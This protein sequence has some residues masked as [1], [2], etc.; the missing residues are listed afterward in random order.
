MSRVELDPERGRAVAAELK[1]L[2]VKGILIT[3]AEQ[4]YITQLACKMPEC[5]CPEELGGACYFEPVTGRIKRLD[6]NPRALPALQESGGHRLVDNAILAHRLCNRIDYSPE[7]SRVPSGTARSRGSGKPARG[8][9]AARRSADRRAA[10][11]PARMTQS[12]SRDG[13]E[14]RRACA[15]WRRGCRG[16]ARPSSGAGCIVP[17][18]THGVSGASRVTRRSMGFRLPEGGARSCARDVPAQVSAPQAV[19]HALPMAGRSPR[20]HRRG[21]SSASSSSTPGAWS[22][23]RS[24]LRSPTMSS[25]S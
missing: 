17:R 25:G 20:G 14:D 15:A 6:A 19:R 7:V 16:R 5:F 13:R 3:A 4:G 24:S 12:S 10:A 9:A 11:E 22:C 1:A 21:A 2:G 23:R 18:R 8:R